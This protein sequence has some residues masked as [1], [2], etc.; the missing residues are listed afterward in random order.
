MSRSYQFRSFA[1]RATIA[2]PDGLY[3]YRA[4]PIW[5]GNLA[6]DNRW[7]TV[8]GHKTHARIVA[9]VEP[10]EE[11]PEPATGPVGVRL[12]VGGGMV[13]VESS[14]ARVLMLA[15]LN[16]AGEW[17][18]A[19]SYVSPDGTAWSQDGQLQWREEP[20]VVG[21]RELSAQWWP[22]C[23]GCL[24]LHCDDTIR[25]LVRGDKTNATSLSIE[26]NT[27]LWIS[28]QTNDSHD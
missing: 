26:L 23:S 13:P 14:T 8:L 1:F 3:Y 20:P 6:H 15:N 19:C 9:V 22:G 21:L 16:T 18:D 4:Q 7:R 24:P 25:L 12:E 28:E 2:F 17:P 5:D 27:T 11:P 10:R